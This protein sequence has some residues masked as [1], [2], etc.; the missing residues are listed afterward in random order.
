MF[1]PTQTT[2]T[3]G[4]CSSGYSCKKVKPRNYEKYSPK[5]LN[6]QG[7]QLLYIPKKYCEHSDRGNLFE[8]AEF[9]SIVEEDLL[10]ERIHN[11]L[12][13]VPYHTWQGDAAIGRKVM[14]LI[15]EHG[16]EKNENSVAEDLRLYCIFPK[17]HFK[18]KLLETT[19][20]RQTLLGY[21]RYAGYTGQFNAS[22]DRFDNHNIDFHKSKRYI[23]QGPSAKSRSVTE[24]GIVLA[25]EQHFTRRKYIA[26]HTDRIKVPDDVGFFLEWQLHLPL[27][28]MAN[29]KRE[30]SQKISLM[31][32]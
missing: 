31:F 9:V 29:L 3:K 2:G 7:E 1:S 30:I 32:S 16:L 25:L 22:H 28:R 21:A 14:T 12:R 26:V 6:I 10:I 24:K 19:T 5:K 11:K 13:K 23:K 18:K 15:N 20:G 27:W 4:K 17:V 8:S